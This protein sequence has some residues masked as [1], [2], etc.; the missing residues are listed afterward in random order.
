MHLPDKKKFAPAAS[1]YYT[2]TYIQLSFLRPGIT[3][4]SEGVGCGEGKQNRSFPEK[5]V[6]LSLGIFKLFFWKN[7]QKKS[8]HAFDQSAS[9]D[10]VTKLRSY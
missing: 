9:F 2:T 8:K 3:S 1:V 4:R 7:A 6:H 10:K 5:R